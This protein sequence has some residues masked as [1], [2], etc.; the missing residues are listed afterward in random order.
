MNMEPSTVDTVEA[1]LI[2]C[3][4]QVL[5]RGM[6]GVQTTEDIATCNNAVMGASAGPCCLFSMLD[7]HCGRKA[8]QEAAEALP[9]ELSKR[10]IRQR[11]SMAAGQGA[12][13]AWS[14]AFLATDANIT[15]EEGCTATGLLVWLDT[16]DRVCLQVTLLAAMR[17][18]YSLKTRRS[19]ERCGA[20]SVGSK[21]YVSRHRVEPFGLR[22]SVC[23]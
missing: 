14:E 19:C 9:R 5:H 7:G 16:E 11:A 8:A 6:F 13:G 15:A 10:L 4:W 3:P 12:G 2:F 20:T 23:I 18:P 22:M 1:V 21:T 17:L